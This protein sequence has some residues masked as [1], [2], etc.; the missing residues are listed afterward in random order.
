MGVSSTI[1]GALVGIGLVA[2]LALI[3]GHL[4][5][6]IDML[7]ADS[8]NEKLLKESVDEGIEL[9]VISVSMDLFNIPESIELRNTGSQAVWDF[10]NSDLILVFKNTTTGITLTLPLDYGAEWAPVLV[11]RLDADV[12]TTYV[13]YT[14]GE[15]V[16]PGETVVI[17]INLDQNT[18]NTIVSLG[19]DEVTI[20]FAYSTGFRTLFSYLR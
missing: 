12:G 18:K 15:P 2:V 19:L 6:S 7:V 14:E 9:Q 11:G 4:I 8:F 17:D 16:Y 5:S 13:V 10:P 20:I 1:S 3:G